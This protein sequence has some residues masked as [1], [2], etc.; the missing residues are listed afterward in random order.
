MNP[1]IRPTG[2]LATSATANPRLHA[3]ACSRR[4]FTA[5]ACAVGSLALAACGG[6]DDETG[7]VATEQ[8]QAVSATNARA[9][10][11]GPTLITLH[12]TPDTSISAY[13]VRSRG[14]I[15]KNA[16]VV[17]LHGCS[18]LW[19]N[20]N[21]DSQTMSH[22]HLRWSNQLANA[23]YDVL[24]VDSFT[25]RNVANQ[26]NATVAK[27]PSSFEGTV[28]KVNE[29]TERV[30]DAL[31][32][33]N[34]LVSQGVAQAGRVALLGWSK[35]AT[36]VLSALEKSHEGTPGSRP[37]A[38]GF[39]YYPGCGM[40]N[41]YKNQNTNPWSS[42]WLP[43][44][45]VTIYHGSLDGLYKDGECNKRITNAMALG[46]GAATSN[47]VALVL[48]D[49]AKHSFDQID[50]SKSLADIN[51]NIADVN[52]QFTQ[53]D[54]DAQKETDSLVMQRLNALFQPAQLA[55]Q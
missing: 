37:F 54:I 5:L 15:S 38:E 46:A 21:P 31:A 25:L 42:T 43:Y 35:G 12:P 34:Y 26:C 9:T 3:R 32:A 50:V 18:G 45:P 55:Q 33:R 30:E 7:G 17:L 53:D 29:V 41:A 11:T 44:S 19:F 23:G 22:I 20:S 1:T 8:A 2:M 13:L 14:V 40:G 47:A 27:Y 16:A 36:T 10:G 51:K 39:A 24:L 28:S 52:K 6:G 4:L 49:G 48:K